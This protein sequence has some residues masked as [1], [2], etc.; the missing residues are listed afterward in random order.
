MSL[1]Q[2]KYSNAGVCLNSDERENGILI[3]SVCRD[4]NANP[5]VVI[6]AETRLVFGP[7][8]EAHEITIHEDIVAAIQWNR[9]KTTPPN[10][11]PLELIGDGKKAPTKQTVYLFLPPSRMVYRP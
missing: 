9:L 4:K 7:Y 3:P 10:W 11:L 8:A 5:L 2:P 1:E 6:R